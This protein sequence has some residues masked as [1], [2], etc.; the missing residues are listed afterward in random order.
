M[1]PVRSAPVVQEMPV[2]RGSRASR[3]PLVLVVAILVR[4]VWLVLP[5]SK[6]PLVL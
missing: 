1:C 3:G 2:R 5:V 6:E 4:L